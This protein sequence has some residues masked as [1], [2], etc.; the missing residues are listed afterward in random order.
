MQC[1][2]QDVMP[3]DREHHQAL[4]IRALHLHLGHPNHQWK[5]SKLRALDYLHLL[6]VTANLMLLLLLPDLVAFHLLHQ[7]E[8]Q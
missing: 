5:R 3:I 1:T 4:P 6:Q 2:H 8:I 7:V